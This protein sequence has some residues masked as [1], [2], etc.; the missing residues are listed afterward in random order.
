[1]GKRFTIMLLAVIAAAWAT[2][3]V[4][5]DV[6]RDRCSCK[7]ALKGA[8]STLMGGTCVRTES[9]TCLMEWGGGSTS[10]V[11]QGSGWSQ[12]EAAKRAIAEFTR[13]NDI[14]L[15][16]PRMGLATDGATP[17]Q[18]ALSNLST[19]SP[20][21]YEKAGIPESFVLAAG[22]ALIRFSKGPLNFL[23]KNLLKN[24]R[25]QLVAVLQKGGEFKVEQFVVR[26]NPGC[27]QIED[28]SQSLRVFVKTPFALSST[29]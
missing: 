23:A 17:L 19:V 1:M 3:G 29:C 6:E 13:G 2:A 22:T 18:L 14:Q 7:F 27:L 20:P 4:A 5:E 26:G 25:G 21:D 15:Q 12:A 10:A 16:I 24:Q 11:L 8:E 9:S 28:T